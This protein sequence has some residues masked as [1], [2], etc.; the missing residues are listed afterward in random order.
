MQKS[1][2]KNL[3]AAVAVL[4]FLLLLTERG[5]LPWAGTYIGAVLLILGALAALNIHKINH[6]EGRTAKNE[7]HLRIH[8]RPA[9]RDDAA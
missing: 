7:I 2:I 8:R 9:G 1:K 5:G 6:K 4:G 3:A